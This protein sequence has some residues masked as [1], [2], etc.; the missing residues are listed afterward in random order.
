MMRAVVAGVLLA[1]TLLWGGVTR[2]AGGTWFGVL[3]LMIFYGLMLTA[4]AVAAS[5]ISREREDGTLGLLFISPMRPFDIIAGKFASNFLYLLVAA[6]A[7]APVLAATLLMGG[8]TPSQV[9]GMVLC[10]LALL[11]STVGAAVFA[12]SVCEKTR[13]ATPV[14]FLITLFLNFGIPVVNTWLPLP[15]WILG[16]SVMRSMLAQ[17]S[18]MAVQPMAAAV[19]S[20]A[21]ACLLA[22]VLLGFSTWWV[23][24]SLT[25]TACETREGVRWRRGVRQRVEWLGRWDAWLRNRL[26]LVWLETRRVGGLMFLLPVLVVMVGAGCCWSAMKVGVD[27]DAAMWMMWACALPH[28]A[29]TLLAVGAICVNVIRERKERGSEL[30]RCA[31]Q[32]DR[33]FLWSSFAGVWMRY[34]FLYVAAG[35]PSLVVALTVWGSGDAFEEQKCVFVIAEFFEDI[36]FVGMLFAVAHYTAL[37]YNHVVKAITAA[38]GT[39]LGL[40]VVFGIVEGVVGELSSIVG[41]TFGSLLGWPDPAGFSFF[42]V[43]GV[44]LKMTAEVWIFITSMEVLGHPMAE[45][46]MEKMGPV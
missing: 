39:L 4:P 28:L 3:S 41:S 20:F 1:A 36:T 44:A 10:I 9:T 6:I 30:L 24:R 45:W 16:L 37:Q 14:A 23:P 29:I 22:A 42:I 21:L 19:A 25:S 34:G 40:L 27:G 11:L 2:G 38:V 33:A 15:D 5:C 46:I 13:T 7:G 43:L 26:P 31:P 35:L 18:W 12:S 17:L 8:V 32:E